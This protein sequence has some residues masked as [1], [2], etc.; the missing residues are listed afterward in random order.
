MLPLNRYLFIYLLFIYLLNTTTRYD[1]CWQKHCNCISLY[2]FVDHVHNVSKMQTNSTGSERVPTKPV[3]FRTKK[4]LKASNTL[5]RNSYISGY[6]YILRQ[7][8]LHHFACDSRAALRV[9]SLL[10]NSSTLFYWWNSM[11]FQSRGVK[12]KVNAF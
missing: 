1:N 12:I 7:K 4:V 5:V 11:I 2:Y 10:P 6:C 8:L 9:F 3:A